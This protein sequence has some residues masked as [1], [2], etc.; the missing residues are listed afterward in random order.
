M[1]VAKDGVVEEL[2]TAKADLADA[3]SSL[4]AARK[5]FIWYSQVNNT[6][7]NKPSN[8]KL[9]PKSKATA[10]RRHSKNEAITLRLHSKSERLS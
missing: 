5:V 7:T 3:M 1:L 9:P 10:S 6:T 2:K 8:R 4:E